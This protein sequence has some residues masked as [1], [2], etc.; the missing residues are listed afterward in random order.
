MKFELNNIEVEYDWSYTTH[1]IDDASIPRIGSYFAMTGGEKRNGIVVATTVHRIEGCIEAIF[2]I[3]TMSESEVDK[4][5]D[6]MVA[7]G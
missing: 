5:K 1:L 3:K 4:S 7:W 2:Y 6:K